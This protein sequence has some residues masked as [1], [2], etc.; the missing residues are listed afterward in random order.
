MSLNI[1]DPETH[2]L[3][4]ELARETGQSMTKAVTEALREQLDQVRRRKRRGNMA[5]DLLAIGRRFASKVKKP[6]V[7]H[8]QLLYDERGLPK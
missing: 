2:K 6:V 1:K 4:Q 7:P 3:A 5:E 8:D